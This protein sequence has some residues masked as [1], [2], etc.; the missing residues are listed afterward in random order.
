VFK[1]LEHIV[2]LDPLNGQELWRVRYKVTQDN[3]IVTPLLVG[4][5]LVTS[6]WDLG[7]HAWRIELHAGSWSARKLW[8]TRG[9]S[10]FT[11]SPVVVRAGEDALVVG[12]SH[13][14]SGQLF[15][16]DP[17]AGEVLWR[18]PRRSGEH[19]SLIAWGNELLVFQEDGSLVVGQVSR[20][21]FR[22][23]RTYV[24]GRSGTWAHPAIVD[25]RIIVRDGDL[26]AAFR[27]D[28]TPR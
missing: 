15:G 10:I 11:S 2:G 1:S 18:G 24:L 8:E 19:V 21:G 28:R 23:L 4:D 17:S 5:L 12:F 20:D 9:A 16:L 7:L 25:D 26:L 27:F 22:P 3:T 13:F 14:N 6:D